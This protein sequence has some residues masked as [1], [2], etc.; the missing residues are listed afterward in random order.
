MALS[1][2]DKY[3]YK[4]IAGCF[5]DPLGKRENDLLGS[6]MVDLA[7]NSSTFAVPPGIEARKSYFKILCII[8]N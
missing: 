6:P 2:V 7:L 4:S 5:V 8:I 1:L 3:A